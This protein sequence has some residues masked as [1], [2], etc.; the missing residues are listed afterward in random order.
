MIALKSI[1]YLNFWLCVSVGALAGAIV[2]RL[3]GPARGV[4]IGFDAGVVT[5]I[6]FMLIL[7]RGSDTDDMRARGKAY[8]PDHHI[9]L[10]VALLIVIVVLVA[11]GVE[12]TGAGRNKGAAVALAGIT[13]L[14]AWL[15]SN[16]LFALHYAHRYYRPRDDDQR[17]DSAE[18][19]DPDTGGLDFPGDGKPD[20]G[21]FAYFAFVLG[22]TFQV[23]DVDITDKAMRRL[24]TYHG[25]AAFL[26]NII[27]VALSVSLI[28]NLLH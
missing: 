4:L 19:D 27:V 6:I 3:L 7:L 8:D 9:L 21:D 15:F 18:A 13:L 10:L 12:L 11:V 23:S 17:G 22:M 5:Y 20:Y 16:L 14:L 25:M 1:R 26:F 28:G 24:A 2:G